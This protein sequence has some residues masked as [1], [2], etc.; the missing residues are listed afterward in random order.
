MVRLI[1][2]DEMELVGI[3]GTGETF[4]KEVFKMGSQMVMDDIYGIQGPI[5]KDNGEI[6]VGMGKENIILKLVN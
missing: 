2:T 6:G 1:R 3:L 4:M 5:S